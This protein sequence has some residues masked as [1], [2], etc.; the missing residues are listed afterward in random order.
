MSSKAVSTSR[1]A[2]TRHDPP[3]MHGGNERHDHGSAGGSGRLEIARFSALRHGVA[4]WAKGAETRA[5][6]SHETLTAKDAKYR[7]GCLID[8]ARPSR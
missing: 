5:S 4:F 6:T 7:F 3:R 2:P 1:Q 8:L